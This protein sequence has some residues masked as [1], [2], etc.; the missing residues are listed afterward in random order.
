MSGLDLINK[1]NKFVSYIGIFIAI[2]MFFYL[3]PFTFKELSNLFNIPST[4][5]YFKIKMNYSLSYIFIILSLILIIISFLPLIFKNKISEGFDKDNNKYYYSYFSIYIAVLIFSSLLMELIDPSITVSKISTYKFGVQNFIYATGSVFQVIIL[6]FI[7]LT[8]LILIYLIITK[9]L[10]LSSL[11][12]PYKYVKDVMYV[13]IIITAAISVFV[14]NYNIYESILL[15]I[16]TLILSYVYIR[17]GFLKSINMSFVS[18][19]IE[20][21]LVFFSSDILSTIISLFLFMWA[22]L[23][24]YTVLIYYSEKPKNVIKNNQEKTEE[25][26]KEERNNEILSRIKKTNPDKLWI[27]SSCPNC[28]SVEFKLNNDLSLQCT[29]CGEIIEK[30]ASG[31]YNIAINN[32]YIYSRNNKN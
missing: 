20:L 6:E 3:L 31:P 8:V 1:I 15:Y 29:Q 23:G 18:S 26:L 12:N 24:F 2:I 4:Y 13:F 9:N 11:L 19:I 17:F 25:Q 30:D 28:G 7:P 10:K 22:F 21:S 32:N 5:L 16:N 14:T 27:R